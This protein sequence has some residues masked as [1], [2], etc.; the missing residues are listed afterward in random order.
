[1]AD[2]LQWSPLK[3]ARDVVYAG[4][5]PV[6]LMLAWPGELVDDVFES[7]RLGASLREENARLKRQN[8]RLSAMVQKLSYLHSDNAHLR[9]LLDSAAALD[10][11]VQVAEV[12]GMDPNPSRHVMI[13]NQGSQAGLHVGQPVLDARGV[14][15][16]VIQAGRV[17]SRIMLITDRQHSVPVR[18]NRNGIR[19]ILSG[20]GNPTE[21]SLQFVPAKSDIKVGD[22]LVTSGL[23]H[24]FPA[25]YPVA[26]VAR[27]RHLAN[28]QFIEITALPVSALDRSHYVL[29]LFETVRGAALMT[30]EV[31]DGQTP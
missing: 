12:I 20:T 23:G 2:V 3:S 22:L 24:D 31:L 27:I 7:V 18:I 10:A 1:M 28:D 8:L 30:P 4:F 6:F 11:R 26:R 19:A 13:V 16:R 21:L 5:E 15:G 14:L 25:G 9:G 17:T 29:A